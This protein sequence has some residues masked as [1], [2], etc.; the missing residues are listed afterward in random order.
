MFRKPSQEILQIIAN[1]IKSFRQSQ[2]L[3][4]EEFAEKAGIHRTYVGSVERCEKNLSLSTLELL[5]KT[6]EV[7]VSQ[8]LQPIE[9][10]ND[11]K[12]N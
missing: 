4:Q 10:K 8:L 12:S 9:F 2:N 1:N 5:S 3:S 6:L 11:K 7:S